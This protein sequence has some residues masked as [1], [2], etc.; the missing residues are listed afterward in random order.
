MRYR[1]VSCPDLTPEMMMKSIVKILIVGLGVLSLAACSSTGAKNG[2]AATTGSNGNS[3]TATTAG[4]GQQTQFGGGDV[5]LRAPYDQT[6]HFA[7]DSDLI[8]SDDMAS[9]NAQCAY[10]VAHRDAKVRLE[11]NTD[12]RGS[13]EYNVALGWRRARAVASVMEQQGVAPSQIDTISYG[14]EKPVALGHNDDS[15]Q[16]NRRVDLVYEAKE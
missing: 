6:Y 2:A 5:R 11:G 14:E 15:W 10:L 8:Q 4:M 13:R 7:F 9:I 1:D 16:L 3:T 12:E